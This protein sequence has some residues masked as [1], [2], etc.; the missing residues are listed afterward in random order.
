MR[1][2]RLF[3]VCPSRKG[4][5]SMMRPLHNR[6]LLGGLLVVCG[7]VPAAAGTAGTGGSSASPAVVRS[8]RVAVPR[9]TYVVKGAGKHSAC[10]Q[11]LSDTPW[12]GQ[13]RSVRWI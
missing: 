7:I 8:L 1:L 9:P 12:P 10:D 13:W 4:P 3:F 11:A 5:R 6:L 2:R